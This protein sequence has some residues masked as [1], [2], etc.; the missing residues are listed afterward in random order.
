[1][2]YPV[3]SRDF[4]KRNKDPTRTKQDFMECHKGFECCYGELVWFKGCCSTG[5]IFPE[6]TVPLHAILR[7]VVCAIYFMYDVCPRL[8]RIKVHV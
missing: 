8:G 1:M 7:Q 3:I 4:D 5:C 6:K 2:Q